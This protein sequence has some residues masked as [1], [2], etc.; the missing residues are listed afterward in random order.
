MPKY[1]RCA[2]CQEM[3]VIHARG[4]C[5]WCYERPE[6]RDRFQTKKK[7]ARPDSDED[8]FGGH[9]LPDSPTDA[10]PGTDEKKLVMEKRVEKRQCPF[11]PLDAVV[12][13]TID[14]EQWMS[15]LV[16]TAAARAWSAG[17]AHNVD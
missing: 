11:H 6:I 9:E 7:T 10:L 4:L 17:E 8:F 15:D 14:F 16:E 12:D 13:D 5:H 1:K 3:C 2:N